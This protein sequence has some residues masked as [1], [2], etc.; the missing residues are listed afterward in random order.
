MATPDIRSVYREEFLIH[1]ATV[2]MNRIAERAPRK[3]KTYRPPKPRNVS[4]ML[5]LRATTAPAAAPDDI[6]SRSG[7]ARLFLNRFWQTSP[8][9]ARMPPAANPSRARG[10]R[11]C[12]KMKLPGFS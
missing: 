6:P 9:K 11:S 5:N 10:R 7:V 8:D 4:W 1:L 12:Q 3:E 2:K